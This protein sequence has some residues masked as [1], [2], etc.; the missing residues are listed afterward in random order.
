MNVKTKKHSQ[1]TSEALDIFTI[2]LEKNPCVVCFFT[3]HVLCTQFTDTLLRVLSVT[4]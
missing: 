4:F 2:F 1:L 3:R